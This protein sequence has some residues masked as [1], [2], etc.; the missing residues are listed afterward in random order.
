MRGRRIDSDAE[1]REILR[2]V[3]TV[4][5]VGLSPK[6]HRDSHRVAA[7]LQASG[8]RIIPVHPVGSRILG[9]T[10]YPSLDA[11]PPTDEVDLIDVF[12]RPDALPALVSGLPDGRS[13]TLWLQF[14]VGHPV[15]E[16][17]ALAAGWNLVANRCLLV[18]HRRL[19]G[20]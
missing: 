15:A 11:I 9:E 8:Y 4:A 13:R 16:E 5:V 7:Y 19:L 10:V 6:P 17:A 2:V 12:R 1:V 20:A 3:R 14:G 18:E